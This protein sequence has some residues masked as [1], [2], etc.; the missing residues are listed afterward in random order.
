M[1][2]VFSRSASQELAGSKTQKNV[3]AE[4]QDRTG[5]TW[6]VRSLSAGNAKSGHNS[7]GMEHGY[8]Q[9]QM[10]QRVRRARTPGSKHVDARHEDRVR[11]QSFCQGRLIYR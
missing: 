3:G 10:V 1:I 5:D 6:F 9:R 7:R 4:G 2:A 11:L 8:A